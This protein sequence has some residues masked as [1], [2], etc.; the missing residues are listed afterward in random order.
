MSPG[1]FAV[2]WRHKKRPTETQRDQGVGKYRIPLGCP[3]GCLFKT[4]QLQNCQFGELFGVFFRR[5]LSL[6]IHRSEFCIRM[7]SGQHN[8]QGCT[9]IPSKSGTA[10]RI[11]KR[12]TLLKFGILRK[13]CCCDVYGRGM[14]VV[15]KGRREFEAAA[16][17]EQLRQEN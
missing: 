11:S 5:R 17:D 12:A 14:A 7:H 16:N 6:G 4:T 3:L 15:T 1:A 10:A 8:G 13:F 2:G 9:A